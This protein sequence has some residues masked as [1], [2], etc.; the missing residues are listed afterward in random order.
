MTKEIINSFSNNNNNS[1]AI[2]QIKQNI[3]NGNLTLSLST[4]S[5]ILLTP[6]YFIWKLNKPK[7]PLFIALINKY[8][9]F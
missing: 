6:H 4:I 1:I 8:R 9:L 3:K 7:K 2:W 5:L